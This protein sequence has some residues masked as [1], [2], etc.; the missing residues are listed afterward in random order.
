MQWMLQR[1]DHTCWTQL[2]PHPRGV[3]QL[4][5]TQHVG[6]AWKHGPGGTQ[7]LAAG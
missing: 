5:S 3:T 7:V 2:D 4:V 1:G 6:T